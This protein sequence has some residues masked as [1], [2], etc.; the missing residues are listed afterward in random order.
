LE[1]EARGLRVNNRRALLR[2]IAKRRAADASRGPKVISVDPR[3]GLMRTTADTSR[4]VDEQAE[5]RLEGEALWLA[6]DSLDPR[7]AAVLKWRFGDELSS[8]EIQARLGVTPKRL[9]KIVTAAYKQVAAAVGDDLEAEPS[10]RRR[11]RS[12][13]LAC[14]LGIASRRQRQ[15]AQEMVDRDATCRAMLREMKASLHQVAA[16]RPIPVLPDPSRHTALLDGLLA[17]LD[18]LWLTL[19]PMP[20]NLLE[21][22]LATPS[23]AEQATAGGSVLGAGAAAKLVAF[24][25]AA[26]GTA[27]LCINGARQLEHPTPKAHHVHHSKR[28][29]PIVEPDRATV[30]LVRRAPATPKP[31]IVA[32]PPATSV[33]KGETPVSSTRYRT[34]PV[35]APPGSTEFGPGN[36]GSTSAPRQPASAPVNGGGEFTP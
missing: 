25:I 32:R 4:A 23:T 1:V 27:T 33:R 5:L 2:T 19:R 29:A 15:R 6:I 13:L 17:R 30:S 10:W 16:A 12:L 34:P 3:G 21:R 28:A 36:L 35:P 8:K 14:E 31:R 26:G 7:Q 18:Q 11:Q 20:R 22:G 9:E 24:C